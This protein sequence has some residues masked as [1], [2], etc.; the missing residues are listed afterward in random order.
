MEAAK[1]IDEMVRLTDGPPSDRALQYAEKIAET[2]NI[3]YS[4]EAR[5]SKSRTSEFI[6][7]HKERYEKKQKKK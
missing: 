6:D 7:K 2:L 5:S 1:Y 4:K 3:E